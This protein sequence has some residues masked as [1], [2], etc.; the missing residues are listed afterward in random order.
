MLLDKT[1]AKKFDMPGQTK[2]LSATA[3]DSEALRVFYTTMHEQRPGSELA[4]RFLLQHGLLEL[5]EAEKLAKQLGKKPAGGGSKPA[6]PVRC[7]TPAGGGTDTLTC[8]I[9]RSRKRA[10]TTSSSRPRRLPRRRRRRPRS[11]LPRVARGLQLIRATM[12]T[13]ASLTTMAIRAT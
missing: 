5:E 3:A 11:R 12:M 1:M 2:E 13:R 4:S 7:L 9:V 8:P 10:T 6:K